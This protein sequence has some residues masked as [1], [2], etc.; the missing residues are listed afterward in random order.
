MMN[1]NHLHKALFLMLA[2]T[3]LSLYAQDV[4]D[5]DRCMEYAVNHNHTV[6]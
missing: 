1:R 4:W 3:A 6:R 2:S 5:V